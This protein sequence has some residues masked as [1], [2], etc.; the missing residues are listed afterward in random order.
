MILITTVDVVLHDRRVIHHDR[1]G[2]HVGRRAQTGMNGYGGRRHVVTGQTLT[3]TAV[4][5]FVREM[6]SKAR[7]SCGGKMFF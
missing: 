7:G 1:S 6:A 5:G 4:E 2:R 3:G